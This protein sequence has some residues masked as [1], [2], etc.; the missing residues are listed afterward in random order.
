VTENTGK[1]DTI[2]LDAG[3]ITVESTRCSRFFD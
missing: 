3:V 1:S 2:A